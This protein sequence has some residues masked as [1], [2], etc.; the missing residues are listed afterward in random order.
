YADFHVHWGEEF[1]VVL[2]GELEYE[3]YTPFGTTDWRR[4]TSARK[5]P[6]QGP[7]YLWFPAHL[8]H[9]FRTV[10][11]TP[12]EALAVYLDPRGGLD[13]RP[14]LLASRSDDEIAKGDIRNAGDRTGTERLIAHALGVGLRV[15]LLRQRFRLTQADLANRA[16]RGTDQRKLTVSRLRAIEEGERVP[17]L[18]ETFR[19]A[20]ALNVTVRELFGRRPPYA[21]E[22]CYAELAP[23]SRRTLHQPNDDDRAWINVKDLADAD[24]QLMKPFLMECSYKKPQ[25]PSFWLARHAGQ[26]LLYVLAG[27]VEVTIMTNICSRDELLKWCTDVLKELSTAEREGEEESGQSAFPFMLLHRAFEQAEPC[28]R[29]YEY[30]ERKLNPGD[31]MIL[32]SRFFHAIRGLGDDPSELLAF[33]WDPV[34]L[35]P[36]YIRESES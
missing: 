3:I 36:Y 9:R 29:V 26:E 21:V 32:D 18:A 22:G 28:K 12:F 24:A 30:V 25:D 17:D 16:N 20:E 2:K 6:I 14:K 35:N 31:S 4:L 34:P 33:H 19:L 13:A 15:S 27:E 7:N 23:Y 10:N 11:G 1:F 5:D 8:P